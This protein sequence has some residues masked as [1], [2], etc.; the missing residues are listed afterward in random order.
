MIKCHGCGIEKDMSVLELYPFPEEDRNCDDPVP[1]I[2]KLDCKPWEPYKEFGWKKVSVCHI[3]FS[4]LDP[5]MWIS[6][7]CWNSIN[8]ITPFEELPALKDEE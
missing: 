1:P 4:K 5:D 6:S 8:P 3:C 2:F 7:R